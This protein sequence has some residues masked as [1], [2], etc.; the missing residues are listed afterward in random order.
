MAHLHN[1]MNV[2]DRFNQQYKSLEKIQDEQQQLMEKLSNN[3]A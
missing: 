3:E 2:I 1:A